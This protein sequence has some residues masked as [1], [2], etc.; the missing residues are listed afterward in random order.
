MADHVAIMRP[1]WR[2]IPKILAGEKTV[3]SRWY[4]TRRA[5]WGQI[6]AGDTVFFKDSG[7]PVTAQ[8]HVAKVLQLEIRSLADARRIVREHGDAI[9]IVE[10]DPAKWGRLPRYCIL[11]FLSGARPVRPFA[12]DKRGFGSAAAWLTVSSVAR[13]RRAAGK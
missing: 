4:Q 3:E 8:A 2:L 5:P 6:A 12:I 1:S 13:I 9:Q 11:I 7:K 10:P